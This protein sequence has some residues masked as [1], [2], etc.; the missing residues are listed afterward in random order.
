MSE[1]NGQYFISLKT[2]IRQ[3][4]KGC[5]WRS[6]EGKGSENILTPDKNNRKIPLLWGRKWEV[7]WAASSKGKQ[8][9]MTK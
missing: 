3:K 7:L 4:A 9:H 8:H 2:S 1:R 5:C 6:K